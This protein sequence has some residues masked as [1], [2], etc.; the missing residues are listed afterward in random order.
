MEKESNIEMLFSKSMEYAETRVN[1]FKLKAVDKS[2]H[3]TTSIIWRL[4]VAILCM[5]ALLFLNIGISFWLGEVLGKTYFGFFIIGGFYL[6]VGLIVYLLRDK[7]IKIPL[8]DF[9]V[10]KLLNKVYGH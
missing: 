5:S 3:V 7:L 4:V 10:K 2:S 6:I 8:G 1:L 9:I